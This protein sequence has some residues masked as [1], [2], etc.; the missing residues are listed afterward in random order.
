[1]SLFPVT[2]VLLPVLSQRL[3][4][5]Q[6]LRSLL[7]LPVTVSVPVV[8]LLTYLFLHGTG[9]LHYQWYSNTSNSNSGGSAVGTDAASY[10]PDVSTAG[11]YYFYVT[12]SGDCS[13]ATSNTAEV[14]VSNSFTWTG[15]NGT[16]W[17]DA[18]NW[19]CGIVPGPTNDV[20]IPGSLSNYPIIDNSTNSIY[21]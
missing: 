1:M 12:V 10:T 14:I 2:V 13:S 18:G 4:S 11:T 5:M 9:T 15:T 3:L 7:I 16:S 17:T 8:L 19:G 20:I 21:S 6:I